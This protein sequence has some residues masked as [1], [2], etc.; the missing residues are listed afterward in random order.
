MII[1]GIDIRIYFLLFLIYSFLGWSLEVIG[2]LI[3]LK[4]FINRGFLVG[5]VCPIYGCGGILI[6]FLL[7]QTAL[8]P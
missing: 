8:N 3:E 2:K 5:P 4:R 7:K 1:Y 6:T